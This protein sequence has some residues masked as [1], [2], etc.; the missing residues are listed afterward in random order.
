MHV[1]FNY[2]RSQNQR[3][4]FS[5]D[6]TDICLA[7]IVKSTISPFVPMSSQSQIQ[8]GGPM[9]ESSPDPRWPPVTGSVTPWRENQRPRLREGSVTS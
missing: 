7:L 6:I 2:A 9:A 8:D 1:H 4:R 3:Y 5:G